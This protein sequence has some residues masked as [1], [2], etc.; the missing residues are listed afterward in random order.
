MYIVKLNKNF[1]IALAVCAA[2]V[3]ATAVGNRILK[4]EDDSVATAAGVSISLKAEKEAQRAQFLS[5]I[6]YPDMGEPREVKE[7]LIPADFDEVYAAY[8]LVQKKSGF[9]LADYR[10]KTAMQYR[11]QNKEVSITL[12]VHKGKIIGGDI[13][14]VKNNEEMLPLFEKGKGM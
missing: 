4:G 10:G 14:F 2:V 13:T 8:N 12:L 6:G 3:L 9:D 7:V 5:A 11:Y 1:I